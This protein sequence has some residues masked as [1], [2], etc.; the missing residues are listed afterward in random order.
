MPSFAHMN[1]VGRPPPAEYRRHV[2]VAAV[3]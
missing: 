2:A 1:G 3:A